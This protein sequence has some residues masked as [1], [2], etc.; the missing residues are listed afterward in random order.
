VKGIYFDNISNGTFTAMYEM[1][2]KF[3]KIIFKFSNNNDQ[4]FENNLKKIMIEDLEYVDG[5]DAEL[6]NE[7]LNDG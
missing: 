2:N 4:A 1:T 5:L 7:D 3:D 6:K